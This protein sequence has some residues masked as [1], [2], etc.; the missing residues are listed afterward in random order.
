[1]G[2]TTLL[3]LCIATG[4]AF[5]AKNIGS[6]YWGISLALVASSVG[7]IVLYLAYKSFI[8]RWFVAPTKILPYPKVMVFIT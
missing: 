6:S 2:T 1:M 5:H 7:Q 3:A 4:I 8:H